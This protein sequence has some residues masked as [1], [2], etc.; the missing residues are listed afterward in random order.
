MNENLDQKIN[1][2]NKSSFPFW[3][4]DHVRFSDLDLNG[5]VNNVSFAIYCETGRVYFR[6]SLTERSKPGHKIDFVVLKLTLTYL[7]QG[8][9]PGK[10]DIGTRVLKI[11]KSSCTL[12]QGIFCENVCIG[13]GETIWVYTDT[14]KGKSEP[15]PGEMRNLLAPYMRGE[16]D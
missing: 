11:G 8:F 9:Y 10:V 3:S 7:H 16:E 13:I 15:M 12:G 4:E 2:E 14:I 5:H 6:E 1:L